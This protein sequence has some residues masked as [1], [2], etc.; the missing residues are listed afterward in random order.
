MLF[1]EIIAVDCENHTKHL[2]TLCG[3]NPEFLTVKEGA[4]Y[5]QHCFKTGVHKS[6]KSGHLGNYVWNGGT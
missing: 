5:R 6:Q 1:I 4:T 2:N 3:Q